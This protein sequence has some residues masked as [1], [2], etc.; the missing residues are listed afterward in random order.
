MLPD[1]SKCLS[2]NKYPGLPILSLKLPES[3]DVPAFLP[4]CELPAHRQ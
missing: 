3:F 4:P 1:E 2:S